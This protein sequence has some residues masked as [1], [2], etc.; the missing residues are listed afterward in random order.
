MAKDKP[1][2]VNDKDETKKTYVH[3]ILDKSGSM[4]TIRNE[5]VQHFN[6]QVQ[7]LQKKT[8]GDMETCVSLTVFD[9]EVHH[10]FL[11]KSVKELQDYKPSGST[12]L[13]DAVGESLD[14]LGLAKDINDDNVAVLVIVLSDGEEN[15]STTY[16]QETIA[17]RIKQLRATD[18]W[19][20]VYIGANQ[21]LE[22]VSRRMAIPRSNMLKFAASASGVRGMSA[23]HTNSVGTYMRARSKG[24][25]F[26]NDFYT[27]DDQAQADLVG[28]SQTSDSSPDVVKSSTTGGSD[29]DGK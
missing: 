6:E 1:L 9:G 8:E 26:S 27:P 7:E 10:K 16:N 2:K 20:F 11:R 18:R 17:N 21:N 12:A 29:S 28:D 19:T 14:D 25:L 15:S 3:I 22:E 4:Q 5:T 24:V 23:A 13:Y